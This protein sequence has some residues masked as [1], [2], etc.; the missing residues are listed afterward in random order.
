MS[1]FEGRKKEYFYQ[2][3]KQEGYRARSAYKLKQLQKK[4]YI[5]KKNSTVV[6]LGAAPGGWSQVA[7]EFTGAKGK[8]IAIDIKP[9]RPFTSK[10]NIL[11]YKMDM[12]SEQLR[13]VLEKITETG[14][15]DTVI[16][17]LAGNVT[18]NWDLDAERQNFLASLAFEA[19]KKIL[20]S[21]GTF[22]TKI[23]RG[24]TIQ[25]FDALVKPYFQKIKRFRPPATR[26]HSAEEYYI[27]K[28]FKRE[29]ALLE[30][31]ND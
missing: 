20:R 8:V 6:D 30:E 22:V 2:K 26:K 23:F 1:N 24:A 25:E 31:Q 19:C 10:K 5:I 12:R 9:I 7:S 16:S 4:F 17:D 21:E 11:I 14:L 29:L 3:A 13:E 15:V 28:G 18:G 27:C